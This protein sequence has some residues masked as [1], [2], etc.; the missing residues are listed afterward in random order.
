LALLVVAVKT[1]RY[2]EAGRGVAEGDAVAV[3]E[4]APVA[5]AELHAERSPIRMMTAG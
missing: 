4:V 2:P 1:T 3:G 5:G